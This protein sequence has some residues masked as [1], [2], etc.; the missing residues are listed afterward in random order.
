MRVELRNRYIFFGCDVVMRYV[1]T[2][3]PKPPRRTTSS[4]PRSTSSRSA[5]STVRRSPPT[6]RAKS[7]TAVRASPSGFV[8]RYRHTHVRAAARGS[9]PMTPSTKPLS[10]ANRP[11]CLRERRACVL[12]PLRLAER[13]SALLSAS[14]DTRGGS[15]APG[16]STLDAVTRH[17]RRR[18]GLLASSSI[19]RRAARARMPGQVS[20][21]A[22]CGRACHGRATMSAG[23]RRHRRAV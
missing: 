2:P 13:V 17:P 20:H 5:R 22:A 6:R 14:G 8:S 12:P 7:V 19:V 23:R 15:T 11:E 10:T 16:G 1:L 21:T 3:R 9:V 18:P 4:S